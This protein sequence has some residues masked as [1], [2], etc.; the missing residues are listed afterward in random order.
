SRRGRSRGWESGRAAE[1]DG[2]NA[3]KRHSA[4]AGS[5]AALGSPHSAPGGRAAG[6]RGPQAS[7]RGPTARAQTP[8][9]TR[10][11]S[12]EGVDEIAVGLFLEALQGHRCA[13]VVYVLQGRHIQHRL[14]SKKA[15]KKSQEESSVVNRLLVV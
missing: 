5:C 1:R 12:G 8:G 15:G 9:A 14:S 3:A 10:L 4:L 11:R 2:G 6:A 13:Q 7:P